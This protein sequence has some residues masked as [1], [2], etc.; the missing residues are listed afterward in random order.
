MLAEATK[1]DGFAPIKLTLT[2][3]SQDEVDAL[4]AIMNHVTVTHAVGLGPQSDKIRDA[5]RRF[6]KNQQRTWEIL[7]KTIDK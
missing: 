4:Y 6:T 1:V 7:D 5:L 2:L 3:Q